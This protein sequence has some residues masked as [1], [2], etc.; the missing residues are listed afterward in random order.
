[1]ANGGGNSQLR[2]VS[3]FS[4]VAP[5][6]SQSPLARQVSSTILPVDLLFYLHLLSSSICR[7]DATIL[8]NPFQAG[9]GR[10]HHPSPSLLVCRTSSANSRQP[11]LSPFDLALPGPTTDQTN[12]VHSLPCFSSPTSL[13]QKGYPLYPGLFCLC[14]FQD[15][16]SRCALLHFP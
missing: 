3:C 6:P 15:L 8:I 9:Q 12:Y 1:M 2:P 4:L 13:L 14:S 16:P 5:S 11:W 7:R 10:C